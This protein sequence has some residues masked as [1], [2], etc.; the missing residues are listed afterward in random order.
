MTAL[1]VRCPECGTDTA[2]LPPCRICGYRFGCCPCFH[3]DDSP[4]VTPPSDGGPPPAAEDPPVFD[5]GH[6]SRVAG[7]GGCDPSAIEFVRDD[8]AGTWRRYDP[9]RD[10]R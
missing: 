7:C 2:R 5:C 3:A 9:A 1:E 6:A 8:G 10:L 4:A